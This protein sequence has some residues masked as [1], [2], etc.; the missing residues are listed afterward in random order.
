M[1]SSQ[2]SP[3]CGTKSDSGYVSNDHVFKDI[4]GP[5]QLVW[6]ATVEVMAPG[7]VIQM[8]LL[9]YHHTQNSVLSAAVKQTTDQHD[10]HR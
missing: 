9:N 6:L 2:M 1:S 8:E 3:L 10:C 4:K 5:G 7:L